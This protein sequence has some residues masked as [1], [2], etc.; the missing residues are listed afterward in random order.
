MA[1][2]NYFDNEWQGGNDMWHCGNTSDLGT[3]SNE[4]WRLPRLLNLSLVEF[5]QYNI[6]TFKPDKVWYSEEY[7]VL[8]FSWIKQSNMRKYKNYWNKKVREAGVYGQKS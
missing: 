4:W 7:D 1:A 5:V 6:D 8:S 2:K 3:G